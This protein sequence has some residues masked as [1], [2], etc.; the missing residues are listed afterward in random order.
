MMKY[1]LINLTFIVYNFL[2]FFKIFL[3]FKI[4]IYKIK[5]LKL[6]YIIY[7]KLKINSQNIKN[8]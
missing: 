5:N 6:K 8:V 7:N 2:S 4:E 3:Y 1:Y